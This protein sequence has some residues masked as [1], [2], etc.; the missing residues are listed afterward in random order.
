MTHEILE[1]ESQERAMPKGGK[2]GKF[3]KLLG[4]SRFKNIRP[5]LQC[6]L[7]SNPTNHL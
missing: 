1:R 6:L 4:K 3:I 7:F 2:D 5:G